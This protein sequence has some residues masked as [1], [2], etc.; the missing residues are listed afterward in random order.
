[1][2]GLN[3]DTILTKGDVGQRLG[4]K[5]LR[6]KKGH[7][8]HGNFRVLRGLLGV[9]LY[10][11]SL[12]MPHARNQIGVGVGIGVENCNS[13]IDPDTDSDSDPE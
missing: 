1:M 6:R 3:H 11:A 8:E 4:G 2:P 13:N 12:V 9:L 10:R 5:A 7:G